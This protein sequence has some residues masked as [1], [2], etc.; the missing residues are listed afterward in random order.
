MEGATR[1]AFWQALGLLFRG[2][3]APALGWI[4]RARR[5]PE[6]AHEDCPEHGWLPTLS[7]LPAL[8]EGGR[9]VAQLNW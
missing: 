9:Y 8:F 3:L 7:A 4:A 1:C 2:D 5:L 6:D